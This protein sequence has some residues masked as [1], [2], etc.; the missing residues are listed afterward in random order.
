MK[1]NSKNYLFNKLLILINYNY[2]TP[3]VSILKSNFDGFDFCFGSCFY[4]T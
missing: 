1:H 2:I 3:K 4:F